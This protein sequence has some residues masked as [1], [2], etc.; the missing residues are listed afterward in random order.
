MQMLSK[1]NLNSREFEILKRS[2]TI[3]TVVTANGEVQTNEEAQVCAHD[4]HI[5]V[6]LQLLEDTPAM[7]LLGKLCKE[8]SYTCEWSSGGEPRLTKNGNQTFCRTENLVPLEVPGLSL[9]ST[10]ASSSISPP[11]DVSVSLVHQI[12]K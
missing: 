6:T 12:L 4:L 2:R 10:T 9:S 1:K 11:Q 8:H 5:F 7:L 3:I